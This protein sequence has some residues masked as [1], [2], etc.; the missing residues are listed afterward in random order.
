MSLKKSLKNM[1]LAAVLCSAGVANAAL[2]QFNVTGDYTASWQMDSDR[3]PEEY[4]GEVGLVMW[5]IAG[6]YAGSASGSADIGFFNG[7]FGGG[8]SILDLATFE[9][10]LVADGPQI[11]SGT[12]PSPLFAPG[13]FAL[14]EYEGT[15]NYVLTVTEAA[16]AAVPEPATGALLLGGLAMLAYARKRRVG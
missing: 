10:L 6:T 11:Y 12:E 5:E 14:T 3:V 9:Y 16:A 4:F 8:L 15:G 2:L 7:G 13:I 1:L